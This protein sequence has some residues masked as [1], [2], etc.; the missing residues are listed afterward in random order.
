MIITIKMLKAEHPC[1]EG[2][3]WFA[4]HN[5]DGKEIGEIVEHLIKHHTEI[6]RRFK[7]HHDS[8]SMTG[9]QWAEWLLAEMWSNTKRYNM[10]ES[11]PLFMCTP[12]IK[13]NYRKNQQYLRA[14]VKAIHEEESD[15]K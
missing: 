12:L 5:L 9:Y 4:E 15:E 8:V 10:K 2:Y 11:C 3:K 13:N 1:S 7:S 6:R 14:C